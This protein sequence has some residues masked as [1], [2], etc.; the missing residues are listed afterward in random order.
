LASAALSESGPIE[1]AGLLPL[2]LVVPEDLDAV[3]TQKIVDI[4]RRHSADFDAFYYEISDFADDIR[5][6]LAHISDQNVLSAYLDNEVRRRFTGPLTLMQR[7]MRGAGIDTAVT[8][9]TTKFEVPTSAAVP[10]GIL[11]GRPAV[12]AGGA[13]ELAAVTLGR[14]YSHSRHSVEPSAAS[15][16]WRVEKSLN[17]GSLLMRVIQKSK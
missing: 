17:P 10:G 11:G 13:V 3:P 5:T 14:T 4:R 9:I 1:Q 8:A 7:L 2:R 12:A 15:Y 6:E 16:L